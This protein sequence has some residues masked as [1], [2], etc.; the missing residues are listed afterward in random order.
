[1]IVFVTG[2][3]DFVGG[4]ATKALVAAGHRVLAMSRSE[5]AELG[6]RPVISVGNGFRGLC[7]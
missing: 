4:A 1:M 5:R 2:A 6:Y 7:A 3:L